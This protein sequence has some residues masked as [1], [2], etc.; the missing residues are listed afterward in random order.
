MKGMANPPRTMAA[1]FEASRGTWMIRRVVHHLD[2]QD[3]ESGD[4]NLIIEPFENDDPV[5]EK[6]CDALSVK[7]QDTAGGARFWW[8]SNLMQET[9]ND[10]YAAVVVNAPNPQD[11]STGFLLRD[12]GYVEKKSVVSTYNF[13]H[14]GILTI[15]TRYDTNVGIERCWFVNDQIRMRVSSVQFLNG[16]AMTTYCTEF[17]CPTEADLAAISAE[18]RA[19][20]DAPPSSVAE[21]NRV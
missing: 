2:S 13:T 1:F 20:A 21:L 8:E 3:D 10:D 15:K 16:V 5:V 9:R 6:V 17:R 18:A 4:S 14:D 19:Q 11:P 7:H 12:V